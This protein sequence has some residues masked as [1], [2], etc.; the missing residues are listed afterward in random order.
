MTKRRLGDT[1]VGVLIY[2]AS[3]P[4]TISDFASRPRK[5]D[6]LHFDIKSNWCIQIYL[7]LVKKVSI[8]SDYS[9]WTCVANYIACQEIKKCLRQ[10]NVK[11][12]R[13]N[14]VRCQK[15]PQINKEI[16]SDNSW[17]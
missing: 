17:N 12:N 8:I 7:F 9:H 11:Y 1:K 5:M 2:I 14:C 13:K 10:P 6:I 15:F 16:K 3:R 4:T